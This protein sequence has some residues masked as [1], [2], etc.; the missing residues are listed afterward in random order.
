MSVMMTHAV[1][2]AQLM[3]R[4]VHWSPRAALPARPGE[5]TPSF[6]RP[7]A[8]HPI[9][10]PMLSASQILDDPHS[11]L[12][13]ELSNSQGEDDDEEELD[14]WHGHSGD[15]ESPLPA[16]LLSGSLAAARRS[17]AT[18]FPLS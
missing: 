3:L 8:P 18:L 7:P 6:A 9:L 4:G 17:T 14:Q 13:G 15:E 5:P 12:S 16:V 11:Y 2:C 1:A 10:D